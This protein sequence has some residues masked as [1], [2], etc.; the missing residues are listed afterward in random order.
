[1]FNI[2]TKITIPFAFPSTKIKNTYTFEVVDEN[3]NTV[4]KKTYTNI[5]MSKKYFYNNISDLRLAVGTMLQ[6]D[7][8]K[9][10]ESGRWKK[11]WATHWSG[12][13][14]E[15]TS[16]ENF[17]I[18]RTT[19]KI[20]VDEKGQPK[21][22]DT[23]V[24][25][26]SFNGRVS[27]NDKNLWGTLVNTFSF[28]WHCEDLDIKN[29]SVTLIGQTEW[30]YHSIDSS[31]NQ[32]LSF[33][34]NRDIN[35]GARGNSL[36]GDI[37]QVDPWTANESNNEVINSERQYTQ[38]QAVGNPIDWDD[39]H[40]V[41][42][43]EMTTVNYPMEVIGIKFTDAGYVDNN[44]VLY[45]HFPIST[46][47]RPT[48]KLI[49]SVQATFYVDLSFLRNNA[50]IREGNLAFAHSLGMDN[51]RTVQY[52]PTTIALSSFSIKECENQRGSIIPIRGNGPK[53]NLKVVSTDKPNNWVDNEKGMWFGYPQYAFYGEGDYYK[54]EEPLNELGQR[55]FEWDNL[56]FKKVV[57][58][59]SSTF[60]PVR[61]VVMDGFGAMDNSILQN[62]I[63]KEEITRIKIGVGDGLRTRFYHPFTTE[64]ADYVRGYSIDIYGTIKN[65]EIK[66]LYDISK[67]PFSFSEV[68]EIW[69]YNRATYTWS[70]LC[71]SSDFNKIVDCNYDKE[72][73]KSYF[74]KNP[75]KNEY[76][77]CG[78][79]ITCGDYAVVYSYNGDVS[80]AW[81]GMTTGLYVNS[82]LTIRTASTIEELF[83]GDDYE[84]FHASAYVGQHSASIPD[85]LDQLFHCKGYVAILGG[86][87]WNSS[88]LYMGGLTY[89]AFDHAGV[90]IAQEGQV[91]GYIEFAEPPNDNEIIYVDAKIIVPFVHYFN[92]YS[93]RVILQYGEEKD[94]GTKVEDLNNYE[95]W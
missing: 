82:S 52:K 40:G 2:D 31:Y 23:N 90:R 48:E 64:T 80:G 79:G 45:S 24:P 39:E 75:F 6:R 53:F 87:D 58:L 33:G 41:E 34:N 70:K 50:F 10:Q 59:E 27:E 14:K 86:E 67:N 47:K 13:A 63:P 88:G 1:M 11:G 29:N 32:K 42:M 69:K 92:D 76:Y 28:N 51:Y 94:N 81:V 8:L 9:Y 54:T 46:I 83:N 49:I 57:K 3:G 21:E 72:K 78:N 30:G 55:I 12:G 65:C 16:N 85:T 74:S 77:P 89:G 84:S 43:G 37:E 61:S 73:K 17:D 7:Y 20:I 35:A 95:N 4:E 91:T 56:N 71:D 68:V 60:G 44:G 66:N 38:Q 5:T 62:L 18:N 15:M 26:Y 22:I 36:K 19:K 25:Y 93:A